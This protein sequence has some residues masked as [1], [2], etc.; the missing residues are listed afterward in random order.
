[1]KINFAKSIEVYIDKT[2]SLMEMARIIALDFKHFE[3]IPFDYTSMTIEDLNQFEVSNVLYFFE[4]VEY[5]SKM[6]SKEFCKKIQEVKNK[7]KK[8]LKLPLV[9]FQNAPFDDGILYVGK[10]SGN[11]KTRLKHHLGLGSLKTYALHLKQWEK[12]KAL[13]AIKLNLHYAIIDL[14]KYEFNTRTE[15]LDVLE[16]LESALH[17]QFQPLLGRAGH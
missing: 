15:E 12:H 5:G 4:I 10:S 6:S 13:A 7:S 17:L 14:K 9:N 11:F 1:M 2:D 16:H 8:N 3:V